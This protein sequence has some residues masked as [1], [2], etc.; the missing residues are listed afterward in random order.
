MYK[1]KI[2]K[3]SML[4]LVTALSIYTVLSVS[5]LSRVTLHY[6]DK[7]QNICIQ[8]Y[9]RKQIYNISQNVKPFL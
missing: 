5:F 7:E 3:V 4:Y 6:F 8:Y 1:P 2:K 9:E